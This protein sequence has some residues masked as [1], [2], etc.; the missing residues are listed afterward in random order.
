M[1]RLY[2]N[3]FEQVASKTKTV[4]NW[5]RKYPERTAYLQSGN[6]L[7]V[8]QTF[9]QLPSRSLRLLASLSFYLVQLKIIFYKFV[10]KFLKVRKVS[11]HF[12]KYF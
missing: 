3:E 5:I 10:W 4:L 7:V 9:C 1:R 11:I 6:L 2:Y 8:L 12:F